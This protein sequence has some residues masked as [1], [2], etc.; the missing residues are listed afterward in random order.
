MYRYPPPP[1]S[2]K[3]PTT[4]TTTQNHQIKMVLSQTCFRVLTLFQKKVIY[5]FSYTRL[6]YKWYTNVLAYVV[7]NTCLNLPF[8]RAGLLDPI[9]A[10]KTTLYLDREDYQFVWETA[11]EYHL[12]EWIQLMSRYPVTGNKA[13]VF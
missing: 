12:E 4:T 7:D 13:K 5:W 3:R 8:P 2:R 6:Q 9:S 10:L 11:Y 1:P